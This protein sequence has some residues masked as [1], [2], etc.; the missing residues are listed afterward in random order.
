MDY[1][2]LGMRW[3]HLTAS[4]VLVGGV[5]HMRFA[6]LPAMEAVPDPHREAAHVQL[7]RN[8]AMLVRL[9]MVLL[10]VTG[11]VNMILVPKFNTFFPADGRS[12]YSMLVGIKFLLAL[13]IFFIVDML[14]GRSATAEKFRLKA[15][16]WLNV[17]LFLS[18]VV[19]VIGGFARFIPRLPNGVTVPSTVETLSADTP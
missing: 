2:F 15:R 12:E 5:F 3:L 1:L 7:R 6:V 13:P 9:S 4:I 14:N 17:A 16:M 8:Y 10:I 18:M 11:L 19:I